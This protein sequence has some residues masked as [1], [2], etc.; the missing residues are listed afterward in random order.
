MSAAVAEYREAV[1]ALGLRHSRSPGAI[2]VG[3]EYDDLVQEGLIHVWQ[4]LGRGVAPSADMIENRMSDYVRWLG[5]QIGNARKCR[6]ENP[7]DCPQHVAYDTMLPLDD[8]R[9]GDRG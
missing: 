9:V 2:R 6:E 7:E 3:A 5:A 4:S 8:F 1:E